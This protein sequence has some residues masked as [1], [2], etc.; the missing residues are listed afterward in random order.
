M[1]H[2]ATAEELKLSL[3]DAVRLG[4]E[5]NLGLKQAEDDELSLQGQKNQAIQNFLPTIT[6]SGDLGL[7]QQNLAAMGFGPNVLSQFAKL[8]TGNSSIAGFAFITRD[9]LTE[10]KVRYNQLLFSGPVIAA[11]KGARAAERAAYYGKTHARGEVVQQV[12]TGVSARLGRRQR[13]GQRPC[14]GIPG[15]RSSGTG[16]GHHQAGTTSNLDELRAR[17]QLQAQQ[18]AVIVAEN[19]LQKDLILLKREIGVAPGQK[20]ALTDPAPYSELALQ[21]ADEVRAVA[22][23]NRQDYKKLQNQLI[24][25]QAIHTAYRAQRLPSLSFSSFYAVSKVNGVAS[26][27]N[28]NAQGNLSVPLFREAG[29]RGQTDTALAQ[30]E[31]RPCPT[32]RSA[33]PDR[34]SGP[35][36][37]AGCFRQLSTGR[38]S[39]LQCRSCHPRPGR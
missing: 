24:E 28:F 6:V 15:P 36:G 17:V 9:D 11:Y 10:G 38:G 35:C 30:T 23:Q 32:R 27:G 22:Y 26:H 8:M 12:A 37:P 20:I 34:L 4:L 13:G 1:A 5:N 2:P 25:M 29:Q 16:P 3:D 33:R 7:H 19:A 21:S 18:Q 31:R 39:P 14:L